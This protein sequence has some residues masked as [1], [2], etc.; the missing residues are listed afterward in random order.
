MTNDN[1][2][3]RGDSQQSTSKINQ[4][5]SQAYFWSTQRQDDEREAQD[6]IEN[7]RVYRFDNIN[8]ALNFLDSDEKCVNSYASTS[9]PKTSGL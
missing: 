2:K 3:Q 1:E 5:R 8:A 6:D 9:N 7:G 4:D